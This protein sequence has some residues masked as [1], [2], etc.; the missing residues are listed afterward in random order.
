[1]F[2]IM[3][4]VISSVL[5]GLLLLVVGVVVLMPGIH[6]SSLPMML[7][8]LTGSGADTSDHTLIRELQSTEG[9]SISIY[10]RGIANPRMMWQAGN[11]RLLVS[12]PK[13]GEIMQISDTDGDGNAD[14]VTSL[15]KDLHRPHGL[16]VH[17]GFLYV[18]ES[19]QVGRIKYDA[20]SGKVSGDYDIIIDELSDNGNHWSKTIRFDEDNWLYLSL[21]S[22]CNVCEE[23][24]ARRASI[25]RF[26]ADG[27]DGKIVARGLRNSAGLAIA[28]WDGS[29][30]ATDNG[31]DLLGDNYPPCEL[32]KIEQD[33]FYGWPYLNGDNDID[34][35]MGA[36][37]ESL[38]NTAK[39]PVFQFSAHNAP[40]GIYFSE[41][42]KKTALIALHGSWNRSQPDGYKVVAL[43]WQQD[44]TITSRDFI[45]GFLKDGEIIGRPVDITGD[46]RGGYFVSDDYA[47]II[48]HVSPN[49]QKNE[50]HYAPSFVSA[51]KGISLE[52]G[53]TD[54]LLARKGA[55]LFI[56][57]N[58]G[59]CH[60]GEASSQLSLDQV[61]SRYTL[62]T[63]AD[64]FLTPTPPMPQ[65]DLD[66]D[67]RQQ[68]AH[69]L[70]R[71]NSY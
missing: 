58:C 53:L 44:G 21:G 69:Y 54:D 39:V 23:V 34:P 16:E 20:G 3:T 40:L 50:A 33:Q 8:V 51:T 38:Q 2:K 30:Y 18:A 46:G 67:A 25:M 71:E 64:Y 27:S 9:Y 42:L 49:Q 5:I 48:Y 45:W 41:H 28:P 63:L 31:R 59:S 26:R 7:N 32:N 52:V 66:L 10:A 6:I 61:S 4:K 17:Q 47:R 35:D 22:T 19:N 24:D 14:K 55:D 36:G 56:Q 13:S 1:M 70:I 68:L 65:F 29:L 57:M 62:K 60:S 43:T 12:S 15:L 11:G 37:H